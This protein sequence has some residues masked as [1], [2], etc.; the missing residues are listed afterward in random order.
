MLPI[1]NPLRRLTGALALGALFAFG[2]AFPATAQQLITLNAPAM[3]TSIGQSRDGDALQKA[4]TRAGVEPSYDDKF[5]PKDFGDTKTLFIAV[6]ADPGVDMKAETERA[7]RLLAEAR[8]LDIAVVMVH[9]GGKARRDAKTD[10]LIKL[11]G[12]KSDLIMI[13]ADSD[14]D[15]MIKKLATSS[16]IP[17]REARSAAFLSELIKGGFGSGS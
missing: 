10:D 6:G 5:E 9:M 2:A 11:V 13:L 14:E 3:V 16:G 17:L 1:A 15:G 7:G 12:P 4:V 8:K